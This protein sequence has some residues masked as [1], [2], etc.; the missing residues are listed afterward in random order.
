MLSVHACVMCLLLFIQFAELP[1]EELLSTFKKEYLKNKEKISELP[2]CMGVF[3]VH[4]T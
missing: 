3:S 1:H 2:V 4:I